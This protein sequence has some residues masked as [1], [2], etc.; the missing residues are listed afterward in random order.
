MAEVMNFED[1]EPEQVVTQRA[2]KAVLAILRASLESKTVQRVVYT[3]SSSA[4]GVNAT[5]ATL[6]DESYWT[7][8]DYIRATMMQGGKTYTISKILTEKAALEFGE[9]NGLDVVTVVAPFICGPFMCNKLPA[10]VRISM[11]MIYG[12]FSHLHS[13]ASTLVGHMAERDR[14]DIYIHSV[15]MCR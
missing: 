7:D 10:S 9:T 2:M 14:A 12:M 4:V 1:D 8:V 13:H 5:G 11:S 6:M 3:A 15:N